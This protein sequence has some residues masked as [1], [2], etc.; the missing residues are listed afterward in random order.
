MQTRHSQAWIFSCSEYI[1]RQCLALL[2]KRQ[3][4]GQNLEEIEKSLRNNY[5]ASMSKADLLLKPNEPTPPSKRLRLELEDDDDGV[6]Q[7][8][9]PILTP[10]PSPVIT[11]PLFTSTPE[12]RV[13]SVDKPSSTSVNACIEWPSNRMERNV[14][15]QLESLGKIPFCIAILYLACFLTFRPPF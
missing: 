11:S 5:A 6:C 3:N 13:K 7:P 2:K 10:I 8:S 15:E 1:C 14:P 12:K 9:V 4:L